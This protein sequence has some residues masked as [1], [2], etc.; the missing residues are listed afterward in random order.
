MSVSA[1]NLKLALKISSTSTSTSLSPKTH[2]LLLQRPQLNSAFCCL[3]NV[4]VHFEARLN[5]AVDDVLCSI[6]V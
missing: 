1:A 2:P 3:E 5:K 4:P 6:L